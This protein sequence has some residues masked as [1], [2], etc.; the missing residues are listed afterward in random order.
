MAEIALKINVNG[1]MVEIHDIKKI[2]EL[3][4]KKEQDAINRLKDD[5]VLIDK[6]KIEVKK[7]SDLLTNCKVSSNNLVTGGLNSNAV[8]TQKFISP[9]N[10]SLQD[11]FRYLNID[12]E[13]KNDLSDTVFSIA[14]KNLAKGG[15]WQSKNLPRAG[16]LVQAASGTNPNLF[17]AGDFQVLIKNHAQAL[18]EIFSSAMA[19]IV[20]T[21]AST[22]QIYPGNLWINDKAVIIEIGNSLTDISNK[23][24]AITD[25]TG[26]KA[27]IIGSIGSYQ[28]ILKN[29]KICDEAILIDDFEALLTNLTNISGNYFEPY[30][31][32]KNI[33]FV[34]GDTLEIIQQKINSHTSF[35]NLIAKIFEPTRGQ[36]KLILETLTPGIINHFE[37]KDNLNILDG[38]NSGQVF[39]GLFQNN[40]S[41]ISLLETPLDSLIE[42]NGMERSQPKNK[43]TLDNIHLD[44]KKV[45]TET[46]LFKIASDFETILAAVKSFIENYNNLRKSYETPT[47][48]VENNKKD[49]I[50]KKDLTL[51]NF[52]RDLDNNLYFLKENSNLPLN[53]EQD[54]GLKLVKQ[55]LEIEENGVKI[56]RIF[57]NMLA[58]DTEI[59]ATAF[60]NNPDKIKKFFDLDFSSNSS[61]F[62]TPIVPKNL[63]INHDSLGANSLT[64]ELSVNSELIKVYSYKSQAISN[65]KGGSFW[66][67]GIAIN[68]T[69][70]MTPQE[71]AAAIN[72]VSNDSRISAIV[73]NNCLVFT[74]YQGNFPAADDQEQFLGL[75]LFDPAK[76]L[77]PFFTSDLSTSDLGNSLTNPS[78]NL[79]SGGQIS[80]N[81]QTITLSGNS[82]ASLINDINNKKNLTGVFVEAKMDQSGN[83]YLLLQ[84][85]KLQKIQIT[86]LGGLTGVTIPTDTRDK[87]FFNTGEAVTGTIN[88]NTEVLDKLFA[89]RITGNNR[90]GS[91]VI[92]ITNYKVSNLK[93][94]NLEIVYLGGSNQEKASIT[95]KQGLASLI[96][97]KI[98][99]LQ[100]STFDMT[101]ITNRLNKDLDNN[102]RYLKDSIEHK[103]KLLEARQKALTEK[104]A[105]A[106]SA[107]DQHKAM[108][109]MIKALANNK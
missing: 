9:I 73:E 88:F 98:I 64:L 40:G 67:N 4:T 34:E 65:V 42:F 108:E 59:F 2:V 56:E 99:K 22:G 50:F 5:L 8:F 46:I 103:N 16:S 18:K 101:S 44:L 20:S 24:N 71:M 54:I 78:S 26:V 51:E 74:Q 48:K 1:E 95:I 69:N 25:Q 81:N 38:T 97:D 83:Y 55:K 72:K 84:S 109:E 82:I 77:E 45:T 66:L 29:D 105:K 70:N 85:T 19:P 75:H 60:L 76:L 17:K 7:F 47:K 10:I 79:V 43:F 104:L 90:E 93:I 102:E 6:E 23:I 39:N 14:I 32:Y 36:K 106:V 11:S 92:T 107:S 80:I 35:T 52:F 58:L 27:E 89:Y 53:P 37:I 12:L 3:S 96:T 13:N 41:F 49:N 94:D 21:S 68:L 57:D 28:L 63:G 86:N 87:F 91:G 30:K 33:T 61:K 62:K 100:P 31:E 15:K